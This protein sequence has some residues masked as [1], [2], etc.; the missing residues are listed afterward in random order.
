MLAG[1]YRQEAVGLLPLGALALAGAGLLIRFLRGGRAFEAASA[2]TWDPALSAALFAPAAGDRLYL[3]YAGQL[4]DPSGLYY[5]RARWYDTATGRFVSRDPATPSLSQPRTLNP[6]GYAYANPA[7]VTDPTGLWGG[8]DD[9]VAL[10]GGAIIGGGISIV[11]Q[12]IAHPGTIDWGKVGVGAVSGAV[13]AEVSLYAGPLAGG[14]AGGFVGDFGNQLYVN[15][16]FN[17]FNV[18]ELT[19]ATVASGASGWTL[20]QFGLGGPT[21]RGLQAFKTNSAVGKSSALFGSVGKKP[22]INNNDILRVGWG[23]AP[24]GRDLFRI[25]IGNK[26]APFYFH[27]DFWGA[28]R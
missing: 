5:M 8:V 15:R 4:R 26:D 17:N 1:K 10:A 13:S 6:Y 21:A 18:G 3:G 11:T 2:A 7:I 16:G 27:I 14:A 25:A 28:P 12:Q 20:G 19:F 9:L 23:Y 24:G 22:L